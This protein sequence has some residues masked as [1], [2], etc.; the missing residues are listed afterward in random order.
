MQ[1]SR[2]RQTKEKSTWATNLGIKKCPSERPEIPYYLMN[3]NP[4]ISKV[5]NSFHGQDHFAFFTR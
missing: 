1:K 5:S 3:F 4:H 2:A